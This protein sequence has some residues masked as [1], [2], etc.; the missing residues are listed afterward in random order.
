M[1]GSVLDSNVSAQSPPCSMNALPLATS[2]RCDLSPSTSGASTTGGTDSK[3]LRT[4]SAWAGSHDGCCFASREI[5]SSNC[6]FKSPGSG[7]RSGSTSLGISIV[8]LTVLYLARITAPVQAVQPA[9]SHKAVLSSHIL[10]T[11]PSRFNGKCS[12][13]TRNFRRLWR[14][15]TRA[16]WLPSGTRGRRGLP[17][18][19]QYCFSSQV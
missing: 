12:A 14:A 5:T 19:C 15:S 8:Q 10:D 18:I 2:A 9:T 3:I 4:Y 13:H 16:S 1:C 6:A 11:A 17:A 7:G